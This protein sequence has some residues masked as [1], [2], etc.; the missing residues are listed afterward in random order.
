MTT[1]TKTREL[2]WLAYV[3]ILRNASSS[4]CCIYVSGLS[5]VLYII[6]YT[7]SA[8]NDT[9]LRVDYWLVKVLA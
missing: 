3:F 1:R 5:V 7:V 4:I 8:R 9:V 2:K 6:R